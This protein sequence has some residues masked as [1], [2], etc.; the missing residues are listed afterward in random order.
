MDV[1]CISTCDQCMYSSKAK[2]W[3]AKYVARNDMHACA[4]GLMIKAWPAAFSSP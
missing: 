3:Y 4:Y 1:L 2:G